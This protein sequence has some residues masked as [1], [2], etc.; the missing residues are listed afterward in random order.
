MTIKPKI[1]RAEPNQEFRWLGH[2][3]MP[4]IFDGEHF[5]IIEHIEEN[6][7]RFIQGERFTGFLVPFF[8]GVINNAVLG[9]EEMNKALKER[10]EGLSNS[11]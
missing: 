8:G 10:I 7:V 4:G 6:R 9:F 11:N 1:L 2:L 3:L 5:F